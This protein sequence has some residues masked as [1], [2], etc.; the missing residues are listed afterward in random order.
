MRWFWTTGTICHG[1]LTFFLLLGTW[2]FVS[3]SGNIGQHILLIGLLYWLSWIS[4]W[5]DVFLLFLFLLLSGKAFSEDNHSVT[6]SSQS[7]IIFIFSFVALWYLMWAFTILIPKSKGSTNFRYHL[8]L[9]RIVVAY[10]TV[11]RIRAWNHN[12]YMFCG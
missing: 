8:I 3:C 12:R 11:S 10:D 7:F 6:R 1:F 9:F 4:K 5:W 2:L